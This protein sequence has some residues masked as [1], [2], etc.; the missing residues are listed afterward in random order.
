MSRFLSAKQARNIVQQALIVQATLPLC[1]IVAIITHI[2][3]S[4]RLLRD[5]NTNYLEITVNMEPLYVRGRF[6]I[7][8]ITLSVF[9]GTS[10]VLKINEQVCNNQFQ[11]SAIIFAASPLSTLVFIRPY[12]RCVFT[13]HSRFRRE[14]GAGCVVEEGA[15]GKKQCLSRFRAIQSAFARIF[16]R[17]SIVHP[18]AETECTH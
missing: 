16:A 14:L 15:I 10:F 18:V 2:A 6:S 8:G 5:M 11:I 4:K 3:Q 9:Y 7:A 13:H 1:Y 17:S 12:R